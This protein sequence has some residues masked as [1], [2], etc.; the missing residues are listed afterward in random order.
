[1]LNIITDR[2]HINNIQ[3]INAFKNN[4]KDRTSTLQKA[5]SLTFCRK[6]TEEFGEQ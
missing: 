5:V 4:A 2:N 6:K 3:S 1:M